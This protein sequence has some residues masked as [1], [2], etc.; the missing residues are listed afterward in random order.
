MRTQRTILSSRTFGF[1]NLSVR[2]PLAALLAYLMLL[3]PVAL[4]ASELN[5][6]R[7]QQPGAAAPFGPIDLS[8]PPS[9]EA[10]SPGPL[11]SEEAAMPA[12]LPVVAA[13]KS[14]ESAF[15]VVFATLSTSFND[16]SGIDHHQPSGNVVV[17]SSV[18]GAP[19]LALI[20]ADGTHRPFSN[21]SG[22]TGPVAIA[23]A[24]TTVVGGFTAGEVFTS[25][26]NAGVINRVA[27]DG[28]SF[29]TI[30]LGGETGSITGLHLDGELYAVTSSGSVW[31]VNAAGAATRIAT[32]SAQLTSITTIPNDAGRYGPI[33]GKLLLGAAGQSLLYA[34]DLLGNVA[35]IPTGIVAADV[36]VI[37]PHQNFF[38]VD[39]AS[40]TLVGAPDD[41]FAGL[42]GDILIAQSAPGVLA[43]IRWDGTQFEVAQLGSAARFDRVAF[44]AAGIAPIVPVKRVYDAIAVVRHAPELNSG[45]VEGSLWQLEAESVTLDGTDVITTDLLIP[46]TP[47]VILGSGKPSF[48]GVIAG[49]ESASPSTHTVTIA[50]NAILRHLVN[51]T[52]PIVL[53]PVAAPAL[54]SGTRD[55]TLTQEGSIGDPAT[56][57]NLGISG[58]AGAVA[59]PPGTYGNFEAT[60]RTAFVFGAAGV[61]TTYNLQSLKL[62]GGA[63]LR[64]AGPVVINVTT[65][66]LAGSTI[67]AASTPKN[68]IL[69]A[70]GTVSVTGNAILYGIVRAPQSTVTIDGNSRIRGTV[71]VDRLQIS[72]NGVLEI[73]ENDVPPPPVNRPPTVDAG[74]DQTTTLPN[75]TVTLAGVAN[76]DGL[77]AG[78]TLS[79]QWTS[80]S[81]PAAVTFGDATMAAT[82]ATFT[83]PGTYVLKLTAN[84]TLLASS[85]E[86]TITVI[87]RNQP[88]VVDAGA[89]QTIELPNAASLAGNVSDDG[90]PYGSTVQTTW[91]Q[92]SGPGTATFANAS[93]LATTVTFSAAGTYTFTL[94]ATDSEA[95][96]TD[97]V[98]ITV[99][100]ENQPPVVNAGDD[101]FLVFPAAATLNGTATDDGWPA[102]STLTTA[103]AQVSGPGS[104]TF[105]DG[106]KPATTATFSVAGVYV[107]RL[108]A[109]DGRASASDDVTLI[110]DPE[111]A[112]P[113][114]SAGVD[115][116][117]EL[118]NRATLTGSVTD[119]GWPRG[120][121]LT[122]TWSQVSGP[123]TASFADATKPGTIASF[124]TPGT[125][126]LRLTG[127]D[128]TLSASDDVTITVDP[129]N[130]PPVVNAGPDQAI[131]LPNGASLAGSVNDD[132]WPRGSTVTSSWSFVSG[133]AGVTFADASK[134][135]TIA[136]FTEPGTYVVRL[137]ATDGRETVSDDAIVT[138]YPQNQPPVVNA[139]PDQQL[140]LPA[141]ASLAGSA[142]DDGWPFGSSLITTWSL[143]SGPGTVTFAAPQSP[144]TSATFSTDGTYV[145]RLTATDSR[146][147]VHDDV[148]VVVLP[149]NIA[150]TVEAGEPQTATLNRN[151][152]TNGGNEEPLVDG[153]VAHWTAVSGAWTRGGSFPFSTEGEQLFATTDATA[154][155]TQNLDVRAFAPGQTFAFEGYVRTG[156]EAAFDA[157]RVVV[158]Y[159]DATQ[160][161]ATFEFTTDAA[162]LEWTRIADTRVAPAGTTTIRVRL[163]ATR[164]SGATTDVWFDGFSLRATGAAALTLAGTVTDDG[165]PAGST[166]TTTWSGPASVVFG[167]AAATTTSAAFTAVGTYTLRL[168]ANDGEFSAHD[169]VDVTVGRANAPPVVEA[170]AKQELRL[171]AT[172]SLN[173]SVVDSDG[174][175]L[176]V[177]WT[178]IAG[179]APVTFADA[180]S[181]AT[182][183][184]FTAPG[185][186]VLRLTGSDG[187]AT[188]HDEVIIVVKPANRAPQVNAG[189]DQTITLPSAAALTGTA[190][191]PEDNPLTIVWTKVSGPG[192][193]TF[194]APSSPATTASFSV[195][196]TYVLQLSADDGELS[197]S[198]EV[199][200]IVEP[201]PINQ[202]PV[203]SA[204]PDLFA[205]V[206]Q[207]VA[208]NG[209][210]TDDGLPPLAAVTAAWSQVSGPGVAAFSD[211]SA[212]GTTVTFDKAGIYVLRLTGS[213]TLLS[214]SDDVRITVRSAPVAAF[215]VPGPQ[216]SV[217]ALEN[218]LA[219]VQ[220]GAQV[221]AVSGISST[222]F[223]AENALDDSTSTRWRSLVANNQ[224]L[225]VQ[226]AGTENAPRSFDRIRFISGPSSEA[227]KN[228]RIDVSTTTTDEAAFTTVLT[229]V[230]GTSERWQEYRLSA[231]VAAR[232]VR[233]FAIDAQVATSV[234]GLRTLQVV[235][236]RL[237]G[238]PTFLAA[239][240]VATAT[241]E[242]TVI[243]QTAGSGVNALDGNP[244]TAWATSSTRLTNQSF[245]IDFNTQH[246]FDRIRLF[247]LD[248]STLPIQRAV[249]DFRVEVSND[250]VNYTAA[251]TGVALNANPVQEFTFPAVTARYVRFFAVNNYGSTSALGI[252]DLEII[253]V[254][255][256][257]SS[258]SSY[259]GVANQPEHVFDNDINTAWLTGNGRITN[260]SLKF[261][262]GADTVG[263]VAALSLQ[264]YSSVSTDVV[265][266]FEL[267]ASTTTDDDSAFT[268]ILTG[269]NLN[270]G[271]LQTFAF[272]GGPIRA[273]YFRFVAK[274][275][276]GFTSYIRI[277]TLHLLG[278]GSDGHV[279]SA[280][281]TAPAQPKASSPAL[282]ANGATIVAVSSGAP[283]NMLDYV[284]SAPWSTSGSLATQ[285]VKIQL[286]GTTPH[287][288]TGVVLAQRSDTSSTTDSVKDFELWVS[289][290]TSDDA[291]F[292]RVL[293]AQMTTSKAQQFFTFPAVEAK[294]LRYVPKTTHGSTTTFSTGFFDVILEQPVAG[295]Y[296]GSSSREARFGPQQAFDNNTSST[297]ISA[298]NAAT[299]QY[300]DLALGDSMKLYGVTIWPDANGYPKDFEIRVSNTSTDA[301]AF[302]TVYSGTMPQTTA[303]QQIAFHRVAEARYV[304]FFFKNGYAT[305][306]IAVREVA[307]TAL[308]NNG[309]T[310]ISYSSTNT[311]SFV[312]S[313]IIDVDF[314]TGVWQSATN[315][316]TNQQMTIALQPTQT[317]TVDHVGLQQRIDCVGCYITNSPRQ[318][319]LQVSTDVDAL[320]WKTVY[321]GTMRSTDARMQHFWFPATQARYVRLRMINAWGGTSLALS[322][323]V[324]FSPQIGAL[325]PHFLDTSVPGDSSI[326]SWQWSF[327]DGGVSTQRDPSHTY[328]EPGLYDVSLTVTD[329]N[330]LTSTR[331]TPYAVEGAPRVDFTMA[332]QPSNEG[333]A[334]TFTDTSSSDFGGIGA[335]EWVWGD[336]TANTQDAVSTPHTYA[337]NGTYNATLRVTSARGVRGTATKPVTVLNV[338]P[339]GTLGVDK[340][341]PWGDDWAIG[342]SVNDVGTVDRN[343]LLCR[344]DFGDGQTKDVVNCRGTYTGH[345]YAS[346]GVYNATLTVTD[347]DGGV[348]TDAAVITA[349]KRATVVSYSGGRG[350]QPGSP[351]TF[352]ATLRDTNFHTYIAGRTITFTIEGQAVTAV[353]NAEGYA[354]A[355]IIYGGTAE[356]PTIV[357]AFAGD[358]RYFGHS[359][360]VLA[361]CPADQNPLDISLVFDLSGSMLGERLTAAR[362]ASLVFLDS[363][364]RNQDQSAAV[365]FTSSGRVEQGLTYDLD[366]VRE[367]IDTMSASGGTIIGSGITSARLELLSAR[368][369]PFAIPVMII[370]SDFE[371]GDPTGTRAAATTAKNAG[372]R[373]I[374]VMIGG[375]TTARQLGKDVASGPGDYYEAAQNGELTGIYASIVS[376][377]C[378]PANKPPVV[379]SGANQTITFPANSVTLAGSVTDDGMPPLATLQVTWSQ[380]SGAGTVTFG[381]VKKPAT[382]ATFSTPGTYVLRLTANDTQYTRSSSVTITVHPQNVGPTVSAGDDRAAT[383]PSVPGEEPGAP[384][385][386]ELTG[387]ASDDGNPAGSTLTTTWSSVSGPAAVTF[388]PADQTTT[389]ATFTLAGTYVVRLTATDG[390]LSATDDATIVVHP[391][392]RPPQVNAGAD[393]TATLSGG[394]TLTGSVTDDELPNNTLT[395]A[396]TKVSGPG[397][398]TFATA[399]Q[400]T[401]AVT[402][403][404]LGTYVLRLTAGDGEFTRFDDVTV[405]VD[406]TPGNTAPVVSAGADVTTTEP[407]NS[408]TLA[409]VATDDGIPAGVALTTTWT[410]VA[411]PGAA[412]FANAAAASTAVTLP[413]FGTYIL[414]LTATDSELTASDDVVILYNR[415]PGNEAPVVNAGADATVNS[416]T[417]TLSGTA[418]DDGLPNASTVSVVWSKVSGPGTVTFAQAASLT[419]AATFSAFG[420][421]VLRLTASDSELSAS[422]TVTIHYEG[423]NQAPV[424]NAGPDRLA[425]VN[426]PATL[427]GSVTDDHLPLG[428]TLTVQWNKVSGPGNVSVG[429][430]S[431]A[432]TTALFSAIGTYVLRLTAND[433]A[434]TAFDEVTI[435]VAQTAPAPTAVITSPAEGTD[436]TKPIVFTGT[437]NGGTT[438]GGTWRLEYALTDENPANQVWTT[439]ASGSGPASG[440]LGTFDPTI[441][442]NGTY[443]VRL[444]ATDEYDQ[445]TTSTIVVPV[446]GDLKLG[447]FTI[448]YT[449]I[450][451]PL[452][453]FP[454]QVKRTYDSRD[455]RKGDFG[456]G[457]SLSI[458]NA[459]VQKSTILGASWEMT[460]SGGILPNYCI[461]PTRP[462]YVTVTFPDGKVYKFSMSL[463]RSCQQVQ[464]LSQVEP[465][466]NQVPTSGGTLGA[467]LA[468]VDGDPLLYVSSGGVGPVDLLDLSTV[469]LYNPRVFRLTTPEGFSYTIDQS[470]GVTALVDPNGARLTIGVNGFTHSDGKSVAFTRD[471]Q[472]RITR[473]T[474][475]AGKAFVYTYDGNGDLVTVTDRES[476]STQY[477]YVAHLL[478]KITD[479]R[480]IEPQRNEYDAAGRLIKQTD[481][482]GQ[483]ITFDTD[484]TGRTQTVTDRNGKK[485]IFEY[486]EFGNTLK[487]TDAIGAV[488]SYTYDAVGNMTSET[489]PEGRTL[490]FTFDPFG[491][492]LT[493]TDEL[494]NKVAYTYGSRRN[495][496]TFT[497][498]R[499]N[500][501][502]STY[503]SSGNV[504]TTRDAANNLTTFTYSGG[505][506]ATRTAGGTTTTYGY[507]AS[508]NV[509]SISDTTGSATGYTFDAN[510][511]PL[512]RVQTFNG[513]SITT[514]FEYDGQNRITKITWPDG[515]VETMQYDAAGNIIQAR[516]RRGY[517]ARIAY[518]NANRKTR[519]D[520]P[521]GTNEQWTYDAEG[522]TLTHTMRGGFTTSF[523][524]DAVGRLTKTTHPDG[525]FETTTYDLSGRV[526]SRTDTAGKVIE[527]HT[528][529]QAGNNTSV[530]NAAGNTITY[531]HDRDGNILTEKDGRGTTTRHE[532][533]GNGRRTRTIFHDNTF[534]AVTYNALGLIAT[535]TDAAG[536]VT[537]YE[538]DGAGRVKKVTGA[539]TKVTSYTYDEAGHLTSQTD[540]NNHTTRFEYDGFGRRTKRIMPLGMTET[541]TYD[542]AGN[543]ATRTDFNGF[544]TTYTYDSENR[545]L[546][547]TP[548]PRLAQPAITFTYNPRGY[549]ATMTDVSGTTTYAY[550]SRGRRTEKATPQGTLAYTYD[551]AGN[552]ASVQSSN[553]NGIAQQYGY[554]DQHRLTSVTSTATGVTAYG[555]DG[556]GNLA[557]VVNA[558][559]LTSTY[560]YDL[561]NRLTEVG[562]VNTAATTIARY[563]YN[564]GAAGN[565]LSSTELNGR[566]VTYEYDPLYRLTKET[567]AGD[568][569]TNNGV[570]AY[571][572]DPVGNRLERLSTV[573][574]VYNEVSTFDANDRLD[575]EQYDANGNV[576]L[577]NGVTNAYDFEDRLVTHGAA[578][579]VYDGDGNR[580]AKI[581]NGVTI[582][583]LVDDFAPT[584]YAQVAEEVVGGAVVRSFVY[585]HMLVAQKTAAGVSF[586][587][588]DGQGSV[589]FLTDASGAITDT[590]DYDAFGTLIRRTG[591]TQN[592]YLWLGE[593][594]DADL[595]V[596]YFRARWYDQATGRF[597]ST[598]PELGTTGDPLTLHRYLYS[599][600]DPLNKSDRSGRTFVG[601]MMTAM[602]IMVTMMRVNLGTTMLVGA[603][604]GAFMGGVEEYLSTGTV[605]PGHIFKSAAIGA[606]L[607]PIMNGVAA[608][609]VGRVMIAIA[610]AGLGGY[611]AMRAYDR[612]QYGLAMFY[613]LAAVGGSIF[614]VFGHPRTPLNPV[615]AP[616]GRV[617]LWSGGDPAR[618]A[619]ERF[620]GYTSI[621]ETPGGIAMAAKTKGMVWNTEGR[622]L[623]DML[624]AEFAGQARGNVHAF[625]HGTPSP[626]SIYVT[627]ELN[628]IQ[629]RIAGG[630]VYDIFTH[631]VP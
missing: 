375:G 583:Y 625:I 189:P 305:T 424:V 570:I 200:V 497:D 67:G 599:A 321:S 345:V 137:T 544:T 280:P 190:I 66:A 503:D 571:T 493:E 430:A 455:K 12:V 184:T 96:V 23:T 435:E 229:G 61:T 56:L 253:S 173:G 201:E 331:T 48:G 195:A 318:F 531:T 243:A 317:W 54:P 475:P 104:V 86:V 450:D 36:D 308:P 143:V 487:K 459:R 564:V 33:A 448:S 456:V 471:A 518:D 263:P 540:A 596:Y 124:S 606:I 325:T 93:S 168:T 550:D 547:K 519:I 256:G 81:G 245:T 548:D 588:Y 425:I 208:L 101:Q 460:K 285:F 151:L 119:D 163:I 347:K 439:F 598:D 580:V 371:D 234:V 541:F 506:M 146:E 530:T 404:A 629:Q 532:Y 147:T 353:T 139:G 294:F 417:A 329:A 615:R 389:Q 457:W 341:V 6:M 177:T 462:H 222:S 611:G 445:T 421:Y 37:P 504:L 591:T 262:L 209:S 57:R 183:A 392:N 46:G 422:D 413:A 356:Q 601:T 127:S 40:R 191:D 309:A 364:Q 553:A 114:V 241:E 257:K 452:P 464:P 333:S 135:V 160:A 301:S 434:L 25:T 315:L 144:A 381:D 486:D 95:T 260:Q 488:T 203:V 628:I 394:A 395:I 103:W 489:D 600:H 522:R 16:H 388:N 590:Y 39:S 523:E 105:A 495:V 251:F 113:V 215:T 207:D 574:G 34:V 181:A 108:T 481:G 327:G 399:A 314:D 469:E 539:D 477:T 538:H 560:T 213:D 512:T 145:L 123:G 316:S 579:Y 158:E 589:R 473:I 211:P 527:T 42:H 482:T 346:P 287:V 32:L 2:R 511:N 64:L 102:G 289:S 384:V 342:F 562:V 206:G 117:I 28:S 277:G 359:V 605:T 228:F 198:D 320:V 382:T 478:T 313:S 159:R 354:E 502:T 110:V 500:V 627:T 51:R 304:R 286:G 187:L 116:T 161:L 483:A 565:R 357:A 575:S 431:A 31:R 438:G 586:Y 254:Y 401:T 593:Q 292:T 514:R 247:N 428:G 18:A 618:L 221:V 366:A 350:V 153:S 100:P 176:S 337:D 362:N 44:S 9:A 75:D 554:D 608:L 355:T 293:T 616:G 83:E 581:A 150:P 494:G 437:T 65:A 546:A 520:H 35:T 88:P 283:Q 465:V 510:N 162:L 573:A 272:P 62:G 396:W 43:R 131:E 53:T 545:M 255:A 26:N 312:P 271:L 133:P 508:G 474:D 582:R 130:E 398:V 419:T 576:T 563:A 115:Q 621:G 485:T 50:N 120:S 282:I 623:W 303:T 297:W 220:N 307:V 29:R 501:T 549:R 291:A 409:G 264:G 343:S 17:A 174:P 472:G 447:A 529:D 515:A 326:T 492:K 72:G 556:N 227:V 405:T 461:Q 542:L 426:R 98:T 612:K 613:T 288:L 467:T 402:F 126:V 73:T 444:V 569:S 578:T 165:L 8:V 79:V 602:N 516:D 340:S 408:V 252:R 339:T 468:V 109:S 111:N 265:K 63:E 129:L 216:R 594:Y 403:T 20:A 246:T 279:L 348:G 273:R 70:T 397:A 179:N 525:K 376:S 178:S 232:Y 248:D 10:A 94:S 76:D 370:Y 528:Y 390:D 38:A 210:V 537:T 334:V 559:G 436:V 118:P 154:E 338:A 324:V 619:A 278:P 30:A 368:R 476:K 498:A 513:Q 205:Q 49:T 558:N 365:S 47:Q 380:E 250:N 597:W 274:N 617:A 377:L 411:G 276:Y 266:D 299:D 13:P 275:N 122:S 231:S 387:S 295:V 416:N 466:F 484:V 192:A 268:S 552:L 219:G 78:S 620:A 449:D 141:G 193:V 555:Y 24:R 626:T 296:G 59:V 310:L 534:E 391:G 41:A 372:I 363:L 358:D 491:N 374:S 566:S 414:R 204:G 367:A 1:G 429:N 15:A 182:T 240:N 420:T 223:V 249:K 140:R 121:T 196:G 218:N 224:W 302:T 351:L 242:A 27:A 454:L 568:P 4:Q 149:A 470:A 592:D 85:D 136:S 306:G 499:N 360:S 82:T 237:S 87:P 298:T 164:N 335:R 138:V 55:V 175:S 152:L 236:S 322:N 166:L 517:E 332:P 185:T 587:G 505:R 89:D 323:F 614:M 128:G 349:T 533:D 379:D 188:I 226:L 609:R 373:I 199:T 217:T 235:G 524:Y 480:G 212:A 433:S 69:Q 233:F 84:D 186:Y 172:A 180:T 45:R 170:G 585:G 630:W 156:E 270:N 155:L 407:D 369:N 400:A 572:L 106:S 490:N 99:H 536:R 11:Q 5:A 261:E 415:T 521:D 225:I 604:T 21:L 169:E 290:T 157:P 194:L 77:P 267:F 458:R 74:G 58:K 214:T 19:S 624:S 361:A 631:T 91:S 543:I 148:T 52:N 71:T 442:Q 132:G 112:A 311:T 230:G 603:L 418:T 90:L 22:L 378:K 551:N 385:T 453:S 496:L 607:G 202:A 509:N 423:I 386:L 3:Q 427:S 281:G 330:G 92:T 526:L 595:G 269:T 60:G 171:P 443:S 383:L 451:V 441:L 352:G 167:N 197:D 238:I 328:A 561:R 319:E 584:G 134:P 300:L 406:I 557:R 7:A 393:Q 567:I 14:V 80:V 284:S 336:A 479:A 244:A 412:S 239:A 97:T 259:N 125:Y 622:P 258:V 142:S 440:A 432:T 577:A 610:S 507:D 446:Q 410:Q 68:L 463:V 535:K 344:F 107:L